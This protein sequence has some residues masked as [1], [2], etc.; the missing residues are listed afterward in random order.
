MTYYLSDKE[1]ASR[2]QISRATVWRWVK[3]GK[4]PKPVKLAAGTTRFKLAHL[5]RWEADQEGA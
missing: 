1:T 4:L 2:Y 3:E 5:E